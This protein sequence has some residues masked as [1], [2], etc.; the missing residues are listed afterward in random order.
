[1]KNNEI[2]NNKVVLMYHDVVKEDDRSSGFQNDSAFQYKVSEKDF[3]EQVKALSGLDV[4]FTFDDGGVSFLTVAA[5]VLERY[6]R[7][8]I[9][10]IATDYIDTP[11]FLTK[12]QVSELHRRGHIIGSHSHSHPAN[13]SK[14]TSIEI[15]K[16]WAYSVKILSGIIGREISTA[17]IPNGNGS[18]RVIEY[19][20]RAGIQDLYTSEPTNI[21]KKQG[22]LVLHG[23][24]VVHNDSAIEE[25]LRIA[26]DEKYRKSRH[27][28]WVVIGMA[29][30]LL[31]TFY[32]PIKSLVVKK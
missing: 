17:S 28:K 2:Q 20:K 23:R 14:M 29:K 12:E 10:F 31:G 16:E 30:R 18:K 27:R 21:V 25:I 6:G 11:G 4:D 8:G 3:D 32:K 7:R 19:A 26:T 13:L 5:P 9:F 22:N 1:M 24:F 15:D